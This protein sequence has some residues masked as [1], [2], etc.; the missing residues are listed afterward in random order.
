MPRKEELTTFIPKHI[1]KTPLPFSHNSVQ[2]GVGTFPSMNARQKESPP[3]PSIP[4]GKRKNRRTPHEISRDRTKRTKRTSYREQVRPLLV[5]SWNNIIIAQSSE[6][7]FIDGRFLFPY[8]SVNWEYLEENKARRYIN[9]MGQGYFYDIVQRGPG[10]NAKE[11]ARNKCAVLSLQ[12]VKRHWKV[13]S[14]YTY[15]WKGVKLS[16]KVS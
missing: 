7:E 10:E 6:Y 3:T 2:Y 16:S 11:I 9:P 8:S 12:D 15:F 13:L 1:R 14:G 5:A 4:G